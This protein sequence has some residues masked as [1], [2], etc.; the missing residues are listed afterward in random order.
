MEQGMG[1]RSWRNI[2]FGRS[3]LNMYNSYGSTFP[4]FSFWG[5]VTKRSSYLID[6]G[7][8]VALFYSSQRRVN[9][10]AV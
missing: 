4:T 2:C 1:V 5:Q 7:Q 8:I 3:V 10:S 6:N 9:F